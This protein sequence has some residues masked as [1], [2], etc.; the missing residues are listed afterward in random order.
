[1]DLIQARD[2]IEEV[3]TH[4]FEKEKYRFFVRNLLNEFDESDD[5][6]TLWS[7]QYVKDAYKP[8]IDRFE[9]L[10]TYT[11]ENGDKID[12]LIVYL[13]KETSIHRART[14][15]RNFIADYLTRGHGDN[16]EAVL[17]AFVSPDST[18]WRFSLIRLEYVTEQSEKGVV[19][20]REKLTPARRYSFLVGSNES[21]HTAQSQLVEILSDTENNPAL[22]KLEDAFNVE[23]VTKEFFDCYKTLVFNL[24]EDV[25]RIIKKDKVVAAEFKT[26]KINTL[27]FTKK[28]MGQIV[29]LYFIQKKG[30]LGV[31]KGEDWGTGPQ[32]FLRRLLKGEYGEYNNFFN[33]ILEHL[34]YDTLATDRGH[35]AWCKH[36]KCRIPFLNGGLF[37]PLDDY[38]WQKTE[39]IIPDHLFSNHEKSKQGDKGTGI[40]DVFDRYNFTVNESEPLEKEVAIDPEMLGKVFEELLGVS[41][42]KSKGSFYT[43]REIVHYMCQESLVNYLDTSI[44]TKQKSLI[45]EKAKQTKMFDAPEPEQG[46]L[47]TQVYEVIIP[48]GDIETLIH[49]GERASD[50]EAARKSGTKSYSAELPKS[51]EKYARLMDEKLRDITVCDPAI[52][53]GA[54]PVGMMT[55][56]VR[57]RSTLTPYFNDI[58]ERTPYHFKR[59]A[60]QECLYGVDIDP[61]A[62]EIAKLRLWLS[63]VVDEEDV[64][65]IKP[66]PNLDYKI[67]AG[68]SLL[69]VEKDL[70][71]LDA[72]NRLEALKPRFFDETDHDEKA[73]IKKAI[74]ALIHDLTRGKDVFD[75]EIYFSEV[76]HLNKG[77]D[78]VIGN[79]PYIQIQKFSGKKCQKEW[80]KQKFKTFTKTGDVYCLFYER[81]NNL[82]TH[83]GCLCFITSNQWMRTAYGK[84]LREYISQNT[85]PKKLL[86]LGEGIFD[87]TTNTNVLL[88]EKNSAPKS[89]QATNVTSKDSFGS[90]QDFSW[91]DLVPTADPWIV[92]SIAEQKIQTKIKQAGT[93]LKDWDVSINYGIKT[94]FNE[95]FI[96]DGKKKD[97]LI[98]TD[99]KCAEIIKPLLRGCDIKRY[100]TIYNDL[101]LINAHNGYGN[102]TRINVDGFP[103]IKKHL[104]TVEKKRVSGALGDKAK[105]AKG[106]LKRDD[107]GKTPYNLR[108]CAY[109]SEFEKEKITWGNL[110]QK[111][112]FALVEPSIFI[113][114]PS[115]FLTPSSRY[116]LSILNSQLADYYIRSLGVIRS[117]GFFEYK[118]MFVEQLLVPEISKIE[119]KPFID[120]VEDILSKRESNPD[121]DV[122]DIE[123]QIDQLVYKLYGLTKKEIAIVEGK[124]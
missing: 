65:Q 89:F 84:K 111:A 64:K 3:F 23:R 9:R 42:R 12:V 59:H 50:F 37:E 31:K 25:G 62:V 87:A 41:E 86:D 90:T 106:L 33:D 94:G 122:E 110:S 58:S 46:A 67:V 98:A 49:L 52:G 8:G 57:A 75:Y 55:E 124:K 78:V 4:S 26:K 81:G 54:F 11:D 60:I 16:K 108:N 76:F 29:F 5:R 6:Q 53:S 66:L 48:R 93:P 51:I 32:G 74:D 113:N 114:A 22:A 123:K 82:L 47:Q 68:N 28:L 63:L 61:G 97:E 10:A 71:N 112:Q 91:V 44:N 104:D 73:E 39:I 103:V 15:Q 36:F 7:H 107:Q 1:M 99:P 85:R 96:I 14:F 20:A 72:Y 92:S 95:A 120:L 118:P 69:G 18:D 77:F 117:G 34:F 115:P 121:A 102:T 17:A 83:G 70:F 109:V 38:D 24:Q 2:D 105:K 100:K 30:W 21:S 56:I 35:E 45:P 116:I 43:P 19:A 88:Y 101:W 13:K 27:D 80:E 119:Q 40:L 79:P